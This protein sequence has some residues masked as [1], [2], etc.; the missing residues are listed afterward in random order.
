[1]W[2]AR[3]TFA[4]MLLVI[5][6]FFIF[7][8]QIIVGLRDPNSFDRGIPGMNIPNSPFLDYDNLLNDYSFCKI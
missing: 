7:V 2:Q 4:A 3:K 6:K 1:M 8:L 5:L